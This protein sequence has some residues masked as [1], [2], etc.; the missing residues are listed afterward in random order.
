VSAKSAPAL[1]TE[2]WELVKA[3][4]Q[5]ELAVPLRG[6]G[7]YVGY[8]LAGSLLVGIGSFLVALGLL[9]VLQTE[10]DGWFDGHWEFVPY[11]VVAV[12]SI[13]VAALA[14]ARAARKEHTY[15]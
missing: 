15:D 5:Q 4:V 11:L 14:L 7:R 9:R 6:L 8:G 1:I 3:Y 2:L 12:L 10:T 13:A